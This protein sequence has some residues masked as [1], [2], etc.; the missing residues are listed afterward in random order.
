MEFCENNVFRCLIHSHCLNQRHSSIVNSFCII[1]SQPLTFPY[2]F[3]SELKRNY[4]GSLRLC[5][6]ILLFH[7]FCRFLKFLPELVVLLLIEVELVD[8]FD[9][10]FI[11]LFLHLQ[12]IFDLLFEFA[13]LGF[14]DYLVRD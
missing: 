13:L 9:P 6:L 12:V 11:Q 10:P 8:S 14:F 5:I 7:N 1:E 2:P 3:L 4:F